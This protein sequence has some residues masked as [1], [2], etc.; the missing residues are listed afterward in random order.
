MRRSPPPTSSAL[1]VISG[2]KLSKATPQ[3]GPG[4]PRQILEVQPEEQGH[5][6]LPDAW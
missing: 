2:A 6:V 1:S 5:R 3:P 4:L